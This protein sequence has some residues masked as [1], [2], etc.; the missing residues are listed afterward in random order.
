M[1]SIHEGN[2]RFEH[3]F[4]LDLDPAIAPSHRQACWRDWNER[5]TY[6]QSDDRVGYARKRA[7]EI[8]AG[9][10]AIQLDLDAGASPSVGD[11][12]PSVAPAPTSLH[13]S[14]PATMPN[15]AR[16]ASAAPSPPDAGTPDA[17]A[18]AVPL[19]AAVCTDACQTALRECQN[20]CPDAA[21]GACRRCDK[22]YRACMRR[23]FK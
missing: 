22:D 20:A 1:Q 8:R 6:G 12:S 4:R 21:A 13:V 3:C 23:C 9:A 16:D 15:S 10:G 7:R 18:A 19:P 5:H 2:I 14:P 11:G 17:A